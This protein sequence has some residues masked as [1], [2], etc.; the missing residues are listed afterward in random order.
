MSVDELKA[1]LDEVDGDYE[2]IIGMRHNYPM[3]RK[4]GLHILAGLRLIKNVKR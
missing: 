1:I 3:E 2:I 4:V